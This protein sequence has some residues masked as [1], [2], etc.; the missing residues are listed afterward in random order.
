M[1]TI[2]THDGVEIDDRIEVAGGADPRIHGL[3]ISFAQRTGVVVV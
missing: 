3:A 1:T 2:T